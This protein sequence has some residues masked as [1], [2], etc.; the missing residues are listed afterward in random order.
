[1][2][3]PKIPNFLLQFICVS[4]ICGS[5][6]YKDIGFSAININI[7]KLIIYIAFYKKKTTPGHTYFKA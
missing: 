5:Q 3:K 1:M 2:G 6:P 4:L 7:I